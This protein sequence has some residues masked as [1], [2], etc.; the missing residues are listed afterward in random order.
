ME[1]QEFIEKLSN[2]MEALNI[3][4][5]QLQA[6]QFYTYMQLLL[7][8][9]QKINLTA[10]TEPNEIIQ[11]HF[12][13]SATI[14]KHLENTR[15][16]IDVG[17]G[18][19]FPGIPIKII[20]PEIEI[21]L[22]DSLN[23][24]IKFLEEVIQ[25]LELKKIKAIHQ[26][27]EEAGK[28]KQYRETYDVVV[29]RAVA[30]MTTL[31]EYTIPFIKKDGKAIYMKGSKIQEELEKSKTAIKKLGGEIEKIE[32]F[33]LPGTEEKIKR[34]NIIIHKKCLTSGKYPRAFAQ[35][36]SKPLF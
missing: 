9:N 13:D 20:K 36:K 29:S 23:K 11:K 26:R 17:T 28:N 35:I 24:R 31:S 32:S 4:L 6:E 7:E 33:D 21:T 25:Q 2:G 22:L 14:V 27:A 1:K 30:N 34:N 5:T 19:G 16:I 15:T 12:V 10:I 8:W 18:A 3:K